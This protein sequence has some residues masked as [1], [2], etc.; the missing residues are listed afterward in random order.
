M[1]T[2]DEI[3]TGADGGGE[4]SSENSVPKFTPFSSSIAMERRVTVDEKKAKIPLSLQADYSIL[5]KYEKKIIKCN[6]KQYSF[7]NPLNGYDKFKMRIAQLGD[8]AIY[9]TTM[10]PF[11]M[12]VLDIE[13]LEAL[14][15]ESEYRDRRRKSFKG[16]KKV[17]FQDTQPD[18]NSRQFLSTTTLKDKKQERQET[19]DQLLPETRE[20][21]C[22]HTKSS[23][24]LISSHTESPVNGNRSS[25][26]DLISPVDSSL[27]APVTP[28]SLSSYA[29]L[30]QNSTASF[31]NNNEKDVFVQTVPQTGID[32]EDEEDEDNIDN[33][34]ILLDEYFDD[35]ADDDDL[36]E[37]ANV[38]IETMEPKSSFSSKIPES[39]SLDEHHESASSSGGSSCCTTPSDS[40]NQRHTDAANVAQPNQHFLSSLNSNELMESQPQ[41][42]CSSDEDNEA[43]S[44]LRDI[45]DNE[46]QS[47]S[48]YLKSTVCFEERELDR[49]GSS[50]EEEDDVLQGGKLSGNTKARGR[51]SNTSSSSKQRPKSKGSN[52]GGIGI[53]K[54]TGKSRK[55][56]VSA[57][58]SRGGKPKQ[59]QSS[60]NIERD[61]QVSNDSLEYLGNTI[62]TT[63]VLQRSRSE[64]IISN[65]TGNSASETSSCTHVESKRRDTLS[66]YNNDNIANSPESPSANSSARARRR[67]SGKKKVERKFSDLAK[68]KTLLSNR[69]AEE[70]YLITDMLTPSSA[71]PA[72]L[73]Y[74]FSS[75]EHEFLNLKP[76]VAPK[77][78]QHLTSESSPRLPQQLQQSIP[79]THALPLVSTEI[80]HFDDTTS[81]LLPKLDTPRRS[82]TAVNLSFIAASSSITDHF[83][84]GSTTIISTIKPLTAKVKKIKEHQTIKLLKRKKSCRTKAVDDAAAAS[85]SA[86]AS[87]ARSLL[88]F[89]PLNSDD[90][91]LSISDLDSIQMN[92]GTTNTDLFNPLEQSV[93][94]L[95]N[96]LSRSR[97]DIIDANSNNGSIIR[98]NE[99]ERDQQNVLKG[100]EPSQ[101]YLR[102]RKAFGGFLPFL[103]ETYT[104]NEID[105]FVNNSTSISS[106]N[107][108]NV[109]AQPKKTLTRHFSD[110]ALCSEVILDG[111]EMFRKSTADNKVSVKSKQHNF[112]KQTA[113]TSSKTRS[114]N[115]K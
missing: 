111:E 83:Q 56:S 114:K 58:S 113:S 88:Q 85:I 21:Q 18:L 5:R 42:A 93:Q 59:Y 4:I 7:T 50:E 32:S 6:E 98:S 15:V 78:Q 72:Y 3:N 12:K 30:V 81:T 63:A 66:F 67:Q 64:L 90:L 97:S 110:A 25:T 112:M 82:T 106:T 45:V 71:Q 44:L 74:R 37:E 91:L 46:I 10:D 9:T 70:E 86:P 75:T 95:L 28:E 36:I 40:T 14:S 23:T 57:K 92:H 19:S 29:F 102:N 16:S 8:L 22:P 60:R 55:S 2:I 52:Q 1:K 39:L 84:A 94:S 54:G 51:R 115:V 35:D 108:S 48:K 24:P 103:R 109:A 11:F 99:E 69:S 107:N 80:R 34:G 53:R 76:V 27:P 68:N 33:I 96:Q 73:S 62:Q 87:S 49:F 101:I 61:R 17:I 100:F 47:L 38:T 65:T 79:S 31:S 13:R 105:Q 26:K 43:P 41:L 77:S 89:Q 20:E 104:L